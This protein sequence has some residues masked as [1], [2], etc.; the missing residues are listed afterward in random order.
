[1]AVLRVPNGTI[2]VIGGTDVFALF[3][4]R[5]DTF[6]LTRAPGVQIPGGRPVFPEVPRLTPEDVLSQQGLSRGERQ[7]LDP[8]TNLIVVAWCRS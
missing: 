5:Y 6:Y 2:G 7:V 8:K 3:L 4:D 1:M